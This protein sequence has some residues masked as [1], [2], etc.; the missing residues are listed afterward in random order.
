MIRVT[1]YGLQ[2]EEEFLIGYR[3]NI[4]KISVPLNLQ[5]VAGDQKAEIR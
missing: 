2:V 1:S 3:T 4:T 5:T